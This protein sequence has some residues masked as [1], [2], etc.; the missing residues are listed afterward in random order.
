VSRNL[1]LLL[2]VAALAVIGLAVCAVVYSIS[3][4]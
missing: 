4:A 3:P 2:T 1:Q